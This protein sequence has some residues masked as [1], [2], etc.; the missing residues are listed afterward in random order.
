MLLLDISRDTFHLGPGNA[1][2]L[3]NTLG[4][5]YVIPHHYGCYDDPDFP[6]VNG[7]PAEVAALINESARRL[8]VLAPGER[9]G[10]RRET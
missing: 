1:A 3:A 2:L 4:S 5:R 10:V 9:F 6:A 7:D 8:R